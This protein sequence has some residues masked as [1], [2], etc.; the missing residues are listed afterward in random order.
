MNFEIYCDESCQDVFTSQHTKCQY[1]LIGG[2]WLPAEK[3]GIFKNELRSIREKH[4]MFSEIKWNKISLS[5]INFYID[6]INYF[7]DKNDHFM[8]PFFVFPLNI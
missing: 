6:L 4:K 1:M 7:F 3:R 8:F 2:V 5:K